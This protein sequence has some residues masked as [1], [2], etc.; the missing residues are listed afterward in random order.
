MANKIVLKAVCRVIQ[1][2]RPFFYMVL[3]YEIAEKY[4]LV[5][6]LFIDKC[7]EYVDTEEPDRDDNDCEFV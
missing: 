3:Y 5:C 4:F 1:S 6:E 7:E 2:D